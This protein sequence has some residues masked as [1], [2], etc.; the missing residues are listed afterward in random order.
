VKAQTSC[1]ICG[2]SECERHS[3][4]L[5]FASLVITCVRIGVVLAAA[6]AAVSV[7][8]GWLRR[9]LHGVLH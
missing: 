3:A 5:R 9:A 6:L 7:S 2:Q 8:H 4:V 1:V